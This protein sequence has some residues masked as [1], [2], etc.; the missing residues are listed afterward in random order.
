MLRLILSGIRAYL[1]KAPSPL[2]FQI[3]MEDVMQDLNYPHNNPALPAG[4]N[5]SPHNGA[6]RKPARRSPFGGT[7]EKKR[8]HLL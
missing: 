2:D 8:R 6:A 1:A 3:D 5:G 7:P 4:R